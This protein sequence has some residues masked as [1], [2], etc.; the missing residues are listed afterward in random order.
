MK[1]AC[2]RARNKQQRIRKEKKQKA[3]ASYSV[4]RKSLTCLTVF[5]IGMEIVT[6]TRSTETYDSK[7]K[8]GKGDDR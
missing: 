3:E 6:A 4:G 8:S 7:Q 5:A 2:R 1:G